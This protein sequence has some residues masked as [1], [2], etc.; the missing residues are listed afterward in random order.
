M[1]YTKHLFCLLSLAFLSACNS[2]DIQDVRTLK[3][4]LVFETRF[5]SGKE[6]KPRLAERRVYDEKGLLLKEVTYGESGTVAYKNEYIYDSKGRKIK[7][8]YYLGNECRSISEF[9]YQDNDS[10]RLIA[11]YKPDMEVDFTIQP[12]YD[13]KGF[14]YLDVCRD[15]DHRICF[16][17]T[18]ERSES[19]R[20]KT[21]TRFNP[22]STVRSK[23]IYSY[24]QK[25]REI[26][27]TCYGE[28]GGTYFYK[29]NKRGL[30]SEE[31]G[32]NT[33]DKSFLWLKTYL[34]DQS[35]NLV[36]IVEYNNKRDRPKNPHKIF[37]Y[38][39]EFWEQF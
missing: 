9:I 30:K 16:W 31:I 27:N 33:S 12:S 28:L 35:N 5:D 34:Y 37:V 1:G 22:D 19:G 36:K 38:R 11:I 26:K 15:K 32:R 18:Y 10:A 20:L 39:Y 13:K 8:T 6:G 17:D 21:W 3:Q 24:D 2:S 7:D 23:V 25:G 14:N 29:Y 4:I